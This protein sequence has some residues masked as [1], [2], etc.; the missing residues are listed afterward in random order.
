MPLTQDDF[1][2]RFLTLEGVDGCGKSTQ[3]RRLAAWLRGLGCDVVATREPGG[4]ALGE[5]IR[6]ILLTQE[7]QPPLPRTELALVFAARAQHVEEVIRPALR[8]GATVVC[9]RFVDATE[10]YQGGGRQLGGE[11]VATLH[12]SLCDALQPDLTVILDLDIDIALARAWR[13]QESATNGEARFES[14]PAE[15]HRRVRAA[16]HAIAAREA[17]RC[18]L[19]AAHGSPEEVAARVF[20]AVD[21]VALTWKP[22]AFAP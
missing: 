5:R 20:Q 19:V 21:S 3:A 7:T 12:R 10:A 13:R 14:E 15:F 16:Y 18:R 8:Q 9:D 17:Q 6:Q 11:I 2:G 1:R 4:T 22:L